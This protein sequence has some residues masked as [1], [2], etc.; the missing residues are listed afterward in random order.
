MSRRPIWELAFSQL[1]RMLGCMVNSSSRATDYALTRLSRDS[2]TRRDALAGNGKCKRVG[3]ACPIM[4]T[5]QSLFIYWLGAARVSVPI[6]R[7]SYFPYVLAR[8]ISYPGKVHVSDSTYGLYRNFYLEK[9]LPMIAKGKK[10]E[11]FGK[12]KERKKEE[13]EGRCCLL[14]P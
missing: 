2:G 13:E 10:K 6:R 7:I 12:K 11:M 5:I 14:L 4:C 8:N 3:H 1:G 9:N